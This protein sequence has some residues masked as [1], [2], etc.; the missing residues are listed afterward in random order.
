MKNEIWLIFLGWLLANLSELKNRDAVAKERCL[1]SLYDLEE[2]LTKSR[3]VASNGNGSEPKYH[4]C[5]LEIKK[6]V[7]RINIEKIGLLIPS[8]SLE[9]CLEESLVA[10]REYNPQH[11]NTAYHPTHTLVRVQFCWGS[12]GRRIEFDALDKI[13]QELSAG[14]YRRMVKWPILR[15]CSSITGR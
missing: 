1:Q 9:R 4:D 14:F 12:L 8:Y 6:L 13:Q 3:S 7:R 15:F 11:D 10:F 2:L 5:L